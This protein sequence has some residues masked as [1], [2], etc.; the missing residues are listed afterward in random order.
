MDQPFQGR[1]EEWMRAG[2]KEMGL[3]RHCLLEARLQRQ[4]CMPLVAEVCFSH[5]MQTPKI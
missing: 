3:E 5:Q 1:G 2:V 4:L